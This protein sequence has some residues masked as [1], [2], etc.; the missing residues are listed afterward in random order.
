MNTT[1]N[2]NH[3]TQITLLTSVMQTA[4]GANPMNISLR[5][6]SLQVNFMWL[7]VESNWLL[8]LAMYV[9]LELGSA[10]SIDMSCFEQHCV[11]ISFGLEAHMMGMPRDVYDE[12]ISTDQPGPN[13]LDSKAEKLRR[14]PIPSKYNVPGS[15]QKKIERSLFIWPSSP[16]PTYSSWRTFHALQ[17]CGGR[18]E[19]RS[20]F[21][22]K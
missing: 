12:I 5:N 13:K 2:A 19:L 11:I 22:M 15:S 17:G 8:Q 6:L 18:A 20:G 14:Y 16:T 21:R 3:M 10:V 9:H 7:P 1:H 4:P